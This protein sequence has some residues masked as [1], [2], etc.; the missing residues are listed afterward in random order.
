[1][2]IYKQKIFDSIYLILNENDLIINDNETD[3]RK[4][5]AYETFKS[6]FDNIELSLTSNN[7]IDNCINNVL[8]TLNIN[9]SMK[10]NF[11]D[12]YNSILKEMEKLKSSIN[13][14]SHHMNEQEKK[15]NEFQT[16]N[17]QKAKQLEEFAATNAQQQKVLQDLQ[18][19]NQEQQK[20]LNDF[21]NQDKL[22]QSK[23]DH[24]VKTI[25]S[26]QLSSSIQNIM[27]EAYE[28]VRLFQFYYVDEAIRATNHPKIDN[29][30][31]LTDQWCILE[32]Q[33]LESLQIDRKDVFITPIEK[34]L[35]QLIHVPFKLLNI[36]KISN[37]RYGLAHVKIDSVDEQQSFMKH[38]QNEFYPEE[39]PHTLIVKQ[40]VSVLS[41]RDVSQLRYFKNKTKKKK[42]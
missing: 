36:R 31:Q 26:L 33:L 1:M 12:I 30:Q 37:Q 16:I 13:L 11:K 41:A 24:L 18:N 27:V 20:I 23:I 5:K 25:D 39:Y 40:I 29:W 28:V 3:E 19:L 22:Q 7:D 8:S 9:N 4:K 34:E 21:K 10:E 17:Q 32:M 42:S 15:R 35:E 2:E 38:M 6:A 14:F